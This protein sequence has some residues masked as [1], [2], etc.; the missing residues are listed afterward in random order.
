MMKNKGGIIILGLFCLGVFDASGQEKDS[1]ISAAKDRSPAAIGKLITNDL[2]S[3]K[4]IFMYPADML[5]AV[6]YAEACTGFGAARLA[7]LLKDTTTPRKLADRYLTI[8]ENG[9]ENSANHVDANV[10]GILP[11]EIYKQTG[12]KRFLEQGLHLADVQWIDPLPDGTT[13]QTRYWIDDVYMIASLQTQAYC[14]TGNIVYLE[15]A[16]LEVNKY[17]ERLQQ[18]NGLFFHGENA[19][20]YWGRGN[21]WV[22]AGLAELLS[23]LPKTNQYYKSILSGYRKMM[24]TLLQYQSKEGMWKQLI[25]HEEAWLETSSSAMFG[26]A[27]TVG[28]KK[29]LLSKKK[30]ELAY[31]KA[32]NALT[33]YITIDG[34]VTNVCAGTGQSTD[35]NYYL[36]RPSTTGDFH[37]QAPVLWF[38][39]AL[40]NKY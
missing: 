40:L 24:N 10:Y 9:P 17:I 4:E 26:Y 20:F 37:G 13:K 6:H 36:N 35:V 2:L 34:K 3:R 11:L 18:P 31:K 25:D 39:Y 30:F 27:M 15:R 32:W 14:V 12:D 23:V 16:A 29:G 7:G 8:I 21:G 38:V 1:L 19:H 33:D 28:V 5:T 22:A